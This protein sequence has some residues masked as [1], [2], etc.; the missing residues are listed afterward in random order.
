MSAEPPET[1]W[2]PGWHP[3]PFSP[4]LLDVRD[5]RQ[6]VLDVDIPAADEVGFCRSPWVST[7]TRGVHEIQLFAKG[8]VKGSTYISD[9]PD[10]GGPL[11]VG[12]LRWAGS[13]GRGRRCRSRR[14]A[15]RTTTR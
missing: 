8:F 9:V 1:P 12:E 11:A 15:A 4:W 3:G 5:N 7:P 2:H 6:T 13:G 14:A 10:L